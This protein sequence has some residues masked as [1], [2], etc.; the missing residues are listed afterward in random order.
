MKPWIEKDAGKTDIEQLVYLSNLIGSDL[1]LVQPGGGNTS[2][3][4]T[5]PDLFRLDAHSLVVKGSG[6][7]LR[8][9][10]PAGF[11]HLYIDRLALLRER[12]TM[13]DEEMMAAMRACMLF[14]DSNPVPSVET[15]LHALLPA[16][17]VAHTH[18]IAT[19]SLTDTPHAEQNVRRVFGDE[20]A[21]LEYV[22]P[23]FPLAKLLAERY[24]NG[25]PAGTT[26]LVM[27]KHGLAVWGDSA[28][29]CYENLRAVIEKAEAFVAKARKGK[30]VFGAPIA[31]TLTKRE[32]IE[33]AATVMPAVRGEL[34]RGGWRCVL[35]LDDSRE[36]L[37]TI[38]GE[39]FAEVA[40][41]GVMTPEHI[42]RAGVRPLV[43]LLDTDPGVGAEQRAEQPPIEDHLRS[44]AQPLQH[45][46][47]QLRHAIQT[48]RDEYAAYAHRHGYDPIPDFLKTIVI[49]GIGIIFAG[50][51][52]RSALVA[53]DCYRATMQV[54]A[55]AESLE[56]FEFIS[57]KEQAEMEYWPLERRKIEEASRRELDGKIALVIGAASGIGRATALR[58]AAEGAHV[59]AADL[60]GDGANGVAGQINESAP[61]RA[62]GV[63]IDVTDSQAIADAVRETVLHF[64]GIDVLFYS[65][66]VGPEYHSVVDMLDEEVEHKMAVHYRGAVAATREVARVM[67][68]QGTGGRLVYNASK[69]AFAPG[70]GFAAYGAS[71]AALVHYVRNVASEL[72][73]DGITAN[74]INADAIDTPM[75]RDLVRLR[76][77]RA[78]VSEKEMLDRYAERSILREAL[79]PPEAVAEAALWL[80]SERSVHT[81]G[82]VIT[83][84]GGTEG[85]PR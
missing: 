26:A 49:P 67:I 17:L 29:E 27:E 61:E 31:A 82:C 32:R 21:F 41:R 20:V 6:T 48:H 33:I 19:L 24:A 52:R 34:E 77:E 11:T 8:A 35:H 9:I 13:S 68:E 80:A 50:K 57:E 22:R 83:V 36:T 59:I 39:F 85:F 47:D 25:P 7:D 16:R 63:A 40:P 42:L 46:A 23:G 44:V 2:V 62:L 79:V 66:G 38:A 72:G 75:F 76:A 5:E 12:E 74:Y 18:D 55:N 45:F 78:N 14:P 37:E 73:R 56:R 10:G 70:E 69:A 15:P 54:M 53:A 4:L 60:D 28:H 65:P 51:D 1:S 43:V 58:F 3:K 30:H 81:T 71:K 64:G 84:G